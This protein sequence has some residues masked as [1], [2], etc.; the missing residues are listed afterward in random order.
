MGELHFCFVFVHSLNELNK[1][2]EEEEE[3]M[4]AVERA[5]RP[6]LCEQWVPG[7]LSDLQNLS[8]GARLWSLHLYKGPLEACLGLEALA[9]RTRAPH[10][11]WSDT[12]LAESQG[13]DPRDRQ[14]GGCL[15]TSTL[16][17]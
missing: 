2:E 5:G 3:D 10:T 8:Q 1:K 16:A 9:Q 14:Q 15:N 11:L 7:Y 12:T 13:C 17:F 4:T 6:A